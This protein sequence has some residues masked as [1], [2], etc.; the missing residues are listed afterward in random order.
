MAANAALNLHL[1][2]VAP[3]P[4]FAR[5]ERLDDRVVGRPKVLGGVFVRRRVAAAD[6]PARQALA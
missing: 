6:M 4:V 3:A 1:V 5:L 2:D